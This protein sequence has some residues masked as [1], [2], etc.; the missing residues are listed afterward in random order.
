MSFQIT[1]FIFVA[2]KCDL[3]P[4]IT[5]YIDYILCNINNNKYRHI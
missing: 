2:Y 4:L 3:F 5:K 1:I